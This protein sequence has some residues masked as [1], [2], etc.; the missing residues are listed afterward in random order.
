MNAEQAIT[1]ATSVYSGTVLDTS[2][3]YERNGEVIY[4][5]YFDDGT[6]VCVNQQGQATIII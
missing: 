2:K 4:T 3:E 5:V 1:K 6:E